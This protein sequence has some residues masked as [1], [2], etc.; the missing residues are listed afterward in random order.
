MYAK[1]S[2]EGGGD[3][4]NNGNMKAEEKKG[5]LNDLRYTIRKS[6]YAVYNSNIINVGI[7]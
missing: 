2:D 3:N 1:G 4:N 5:Q 6:C 7:N